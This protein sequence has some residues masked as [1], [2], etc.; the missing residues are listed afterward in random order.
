MVVHHR[1]EN[2]LARADELIAVGNQSAALQILHETIISRAFQHNAMALESILQRFVEL[3]VDLRRGRLAKDGL[4]Q[5][6]SASQNVNLAGLES[7]MKNFLERSE[8]RLEEA[9]KN[10]SVGVEDVNVGDLEGACEYQLSTVWSAPQLDER[11]RAGH[12]TITPWL[13]FVWE[14]YRIILDICRH[15]SRLEALYRVIVERAFAFCRRYGRKAEF[16]RLSEMLRHHLGLIVKFPN[17]QNGVSLTDPAS[18]QLQLELRFEQLSVATEMELWHE[19]FRSIEDIHGLFVLARKSAKPSLIITY[20]DRLCRVFQMSGNYLYLAAT[21]CKLFSLAKSQNETKLMLDDSSK[22]VLAIAASPL[23]RD[24]DVTN[25]MAVEELEAKNTRLAHFIGL[26]KAPTRIGVINDFH[27]REIMSRA[28]PRVQHL[29]TLLEADAETS[30]IDKNAIE[31]LLSELAIS[32]EAYRPFILPIYKNVVARILTYVSSQKIPSTISLAELKQKIAMPKL[33]IPLDFDLE[34]FILEG[35]RSGDF[36][37]KINHLDDSI[38]FSKRCFAPES[39]IEINDP[40]KN[41][42]VQLWTMVREF[43]QKMGIKPEETTSSFAPFDV[44]KMMEEARDNLDREHRANLA[45]RRKIEKRREQLEELQRQKEREEARERA[46]RQEKDREAERLR[47]AEESARREA[48]RRDAEKEE[49]RREMAKK[50]D[51]EEQKKKEAA[52]RRAN[53]EKMIAVVKRYDHLERAYRQEEIPL[54]QA[55][56]ERQ[57]KEDRAAYEERVRLVKEKSL[58]QHSLDK[59]LKTRL[60]GMT[61]EYEAY[62]AE[63]K[64]RRE[65]AAK[66]KAE[67]AA[68]ELEKAKEARRIKIREQARLRREAEE[69]KA[70]DAEERQMRDAKEEKAAEE[71]LQPAQETQSPVPSKGTYVPPSKRNAAAAEPTSSSSAFGRPNPSSSSSAFSGGWRRQA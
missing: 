45:R 47:M 11:D 16:R 27:Q 34:S 66:A 43:C 52:L 38:T 12:Q 3:C 49:I 33:E 17:Q 63:V 51:E 62:L 5:Y 23:L 31:S 40:E 71:P 65:E 37:L 6:R 67:V 44:K 36:H 28:D 50:R 68:A 19:A 30:L 53:L 46:L 7:V 64:K 32:N 15:N 18:H 22:A 25:S 59:E 54:L 24:H 4:H 55:D 10:G 61:A 48:Q 41:L 57:K 35:V 8:M 69:R 56:Y 60:S 1:W 9:V 70:R 39:R 42:E 58:A 2:V 21:L 13:R 26:Q 20:Y 29:F 14:A